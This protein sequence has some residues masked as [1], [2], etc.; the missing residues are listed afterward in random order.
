MDKPAEE[1]EHGHG[2][3][4]TTESAL[5]NTPG[6]VGLGVFSLVQVDARSP[7]VVTTAWCF[8]AAATGWWATSVKLP[9]GSA[10]G[11][12]PSGQAR[13]AK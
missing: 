1:E 10:R 12:G 13:D 5:R 11:K 7:V 9:P 2:R 8:R 4:T 6:P 3:H